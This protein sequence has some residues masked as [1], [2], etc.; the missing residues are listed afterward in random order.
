MPADPADRTCKSSSR[1][2]GSETAR[3][4][5]RSAGHC[6]RCHA[7]HTTPRRAALSRPA[8]VLVARPRRWHVATHAGGKALA[9]RGL[10]GLPPGGALCERLDGLAGAVRAAAPPTATGSGWPGADERTL[11][12]RLGKHLRQTGQLF[13]PGPETAVLGG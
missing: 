13:L 5:I 4:S 10:F 3:S 11:P 1:T 9:K 2:R 7:A 12:R 8:A 6:R